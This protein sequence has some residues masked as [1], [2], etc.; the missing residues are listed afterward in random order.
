MAR[1]VHSPHDL[2]AGDSAALTAYKTHCQAAVEDF[3]ASH[4]P[5]FRFIV[6]AIDP[7]HV[8]LQSVMERVA[9]RNIPKVVPPRLMEPLGSSE[10]LFACRACCRPCP[11]QT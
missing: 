2:E 6:P 5:Q 11:A 4:Q 10:C 1:L 8:V 9:M 3:I 7:P